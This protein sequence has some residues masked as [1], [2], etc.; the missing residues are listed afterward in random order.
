MAPKLSPTQSHVLFDFLGDHQMVPL[1]LTWVSVRVRAEEL[2]PHLYHLALGTTCHLG[3]ILTAWTQPCVQHQGES[4]QDLHAG[5]WGCLPATSVDGKG[6]TTSCG[7][8]VVGKGLLYY[9]EDRH[10]KVLG[11]KF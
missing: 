8:L 3:S 2:I 1:L 4:D 11:Q 9:Q 5:C 10:R 6:T 7:K